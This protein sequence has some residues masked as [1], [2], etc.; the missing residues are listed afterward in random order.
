VRA[1]LRTLAH[2]ALCAS[3]FHAEMETIFG[4][5]GKPKVYLVRNGN[6][7]HRNLYE[8]SCYT[9]FIIGSSEEE[10]GRGQLWKQ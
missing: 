3:N 4:V 7:N 10:A 6:G 9:Q 1:T 8:R 5:R 2:R